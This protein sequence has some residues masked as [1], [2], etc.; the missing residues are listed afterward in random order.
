MSQPKYPVT[1]ENIKALLLCYYPEDWVNDGSIWQLKATIFN[2][3]WGISMAELE[4]CLLRLKSVL[5]ENPYH[6]LNDLKNSP[7][8]VR[9]AIAL[10][11]SYI[12]KHPTNH[13][14]RTLR[15]VTPLYEAKYP[16]CYISYI[17]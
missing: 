8:L 9:Y 2:G 14:F 7:E 15:S 17:R 3:N 16:D 4:F 10:Q 11:Y 12:D 13:F 1:E 5:A 6:S